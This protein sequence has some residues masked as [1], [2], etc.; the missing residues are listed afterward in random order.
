VLTNVDQSVELVILAGAFVAVVGGWWKWMRPRIKAIGHDV[1]AGRDSLIG[2]AAIHDSITGKELVPALPS[3]GQRLSHYEERVDTI[4][5][6][7]V[8]LAANTADL[9]EQRAHIV[10][11]ESRVNRLEENTIERTVA[12]AESMT[13]YAAM[14][15]AIKADPAE[16]TSP[17]E[18]HRT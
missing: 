17:I 14:E 3:M 18:D 2:R 7:M 4:A 8:A 13:A 6:A 9:S 5:E 16:H 10:D 12:R 1:R 15:A 11:L